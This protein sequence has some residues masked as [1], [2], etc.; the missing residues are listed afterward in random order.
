DY[1][2]SSWQTCAALAHLCAGR[3]DDAI[4]SARAALRSTPHYSSAMRIAAASY[5]LAGRSAEAL[6]MVTRLRELDPTLQLANLGDVLQPLRRTADRDMMFE[7]L[8]QAGL[9]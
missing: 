9:E 6:D 4:V 5:A 1:R 7:A 8:R 3:Y 2:L